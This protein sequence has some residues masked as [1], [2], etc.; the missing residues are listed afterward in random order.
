MLKINV[1][2]NKFKIVQITD[3]HISNQIADN[4]RASI[5]NIIKLEKPDLLVFTGDVFHRP[6]SEQESV[7]L[8]DSFI[9]MIDE[10]KTHYTFV[11]GNHD[12]ELMLTKFQIYN[13]FLN[14]SMYFV[15]EV[16]SDELIRFHINDSKYRSPRIGNFWLKIENN[17]ETVAQLCL[18]DSGRYN[19]NGGEGSL[20]L[21]QVKFIKDSYE[22]ANGPLLLFFHIPLLQNS[23]MYKTSLAK[24]LMRE[25]V[26]YQEEDC[27]LYEWAINQSN[28]IHVNTGH[29]H[30]NDYELVI[31]NVHLNATPGLCF[32]EYNEN[33]LRGYRVITLG[34]TMTSKNKRLCDIPGS[35]ND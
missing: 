1:E 9:E 13:K 31:D 6:H 3:I 23:T 25:N 29:D 12:A 26:C 10:Y 8:I 11:F 28:E 17:N 35:M 33:G 34:D 21:H 7:Q 27:G 15:G 18:L 14:K 4:V 2:K 22:E 20:T 16:G 24:G 30:I 5:N 19:N 32:E